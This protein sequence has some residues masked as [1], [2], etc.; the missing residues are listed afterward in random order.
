MDLNPSSLAHTARRIVRY[1]PEVREGDVL[2]PLVPRPA[3]FD[4]LGMATLLHCVPGPMAHKAVAFD[5]AAEVMNPGAVLFGSTLL[6]RGVRAPHLS[7]VVIRRLNRRGVFSNLEDD[8]PSL[9]D[10]LERRFPEVRI[11]VVGLMALFVARAH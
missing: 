11:E 2:R 8:L 9:R 4:S 1:A 10:A 6:G 5:H 3:P 7:R